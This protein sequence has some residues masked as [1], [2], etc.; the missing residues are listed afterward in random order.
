MGKLGIDP[1]ELESVDYAFTGWIV[2]LTGALNWTKG[3][4]T[5]E[6]AS[7]RIQVIKRA[8]SLY[9]FSLVIG[10]SQ[11]AYGLNHSPIVNHFSPMA[12]GNLTVPQIQSIVTVGADLRGAMAGLTLFPFYSELQGRLQVLA[13]CDFVGAQEYR[14]RFG[15]AIVPQL[16]IRFQTTPWLSFS[17]GYEKLEAITF[18][19]DVQL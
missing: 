6:D 11:Y 13:Q 8:G 5:N 18:S 2:Q 7:L 15:D 16:G 1:F 17:V 12:A 3:T 4:L 14:N 10:V 19:A 9:P